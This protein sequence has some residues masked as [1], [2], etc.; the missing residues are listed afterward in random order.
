MHLPK[1]VRY[2]AQITDRE[3][4][5]P[6][7]KIP[8]YV[9]KSNYTITFKIYMATFSFLLCALRKTSLHAIN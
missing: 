1:S 8:P 5:N 3:M 7:S 9:Y 4:L 6:E 2:G